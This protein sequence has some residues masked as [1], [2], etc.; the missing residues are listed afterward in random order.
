MSFAFSNTKEIGGYFS[1]E[2]GFRSSIPHDKGVLLNSG[3]NALEYILRSLPEIQHI[4]LPFYT[5]DV[6]MEP[7]EKLGIPYSRYHI[8]NKLH[9]TDDVRLDENTYVLYTNYFGLMDD[10]V[11]QLA[12]QYGTHLI[13][14]NAQAW[15]SEPLEGVSTFYS[16]RKFFGLPDGGVAFCHYGIDSCQ[17]EIDVSYDRCSH[18]LKRIDLGATEGYA[19]FKKNS[20]SL[21]RQ[22]IRRMSSLT[23]VLMSGIDYNYASSRRIE[24]YQILDLALR[25]TNKLSLSLQDGVVPMVYPYLSDNVSLKKHL[26]DNRVFV[27]TYWPNVLEWCTFDDYE[28]LLARNTDFLPV[29]QRYSENEMQRVIKIIHGETN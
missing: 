22:P 27:A 20:Y 3:R 12:N 1:L 11:R 25:N 7:V 2:A 15:F 29:D 4:W 21:K 13:V 18:L 6:V 10:Y 16:P 24:N 23:K 9:I 14:D 5:C 28:Y 26:I 8:D 19:D 17:F